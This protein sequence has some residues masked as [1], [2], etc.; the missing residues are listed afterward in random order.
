M[1]LLLALSSTDISA[2]SYYVKYPH[3]IG[4][5]GQYNLEESNLGIGLSFVSGAKRNGFE[6]DI[7]KFES[8]LAL[9]GLWQYRFSI[10]DATM[11]YMG[12]GCDWQISNSI[13]GVGYQIGLLF[14]IGRINFSFDVRWMID[15]NSD[16]YDPNTYWLLT[17]GLRYKFAL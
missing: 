3:A 17:T 12:I 16:F 2:Q 7:S 13:F 6:I 10:S 8:D 15:V 4:L 5:I 14:D 9:T 11:Y 1:L